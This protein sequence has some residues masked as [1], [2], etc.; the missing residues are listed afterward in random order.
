MAHGPA[1]I[2]MGHGEYFINRWCWL[3]VRF[4]HCCDPT[5]LEK[6]AKMPLEGFNIDFLVA[7]HATSRYREISRSLAIIILIDD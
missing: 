6:V 3:G 4:F 7:C 2:H 1:A 5:S